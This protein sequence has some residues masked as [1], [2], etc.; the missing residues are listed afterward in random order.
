M[1][2]V[3]LVLILLGMPFAARSRSSGALAGIGL[4]MVLVVVYYICLATSRQLGGI[5]MLPPTLAAWSPSA[6]FASFGLY[7]MLATRG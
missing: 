3:P 7:R 1:A 5:G 6:L 4:A 2:S